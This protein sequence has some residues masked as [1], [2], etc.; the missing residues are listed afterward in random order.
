MPQKTLTKLQEYPTNTTQRD[1]GS[2]KTHQ[3]G[4][5]QHCPGRKRKGEGRKENREEE[6]EIGT[7]AKCTWGQ[8][9]GSPEGQKSAERQKDH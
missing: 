6:R 2:L 8:H 4:N 1:L 5:A 7:K 9:Q 3:R